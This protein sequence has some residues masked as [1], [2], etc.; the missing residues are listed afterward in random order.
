MLS[1]HDE[2]VMNPRLSMESATQLAVFFDRTSAL[3][4]LSKADNSCSRYFAPSIPLF[5]WS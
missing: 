2:P 4:S 3:G 1:E 5:A